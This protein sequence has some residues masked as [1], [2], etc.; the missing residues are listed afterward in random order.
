M[1]FSRVE[2]FWRNLFW[3][4]IPLDVDSFECSKQRKTAS[5]FILVAIDPHPGFVVPSFKN[6]SWLFFCVVGLRD[7]NLIQTKTWLRLR[8]K[9]SEFEDVKF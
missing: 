3:R 9:F 5:S 4:N 1:D 6:R 2:N 8:D 7:C